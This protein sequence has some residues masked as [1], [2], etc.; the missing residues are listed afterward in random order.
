LGEDHTKYARKILA[1]NGN[2]SS[3]TILFVLKEIMESPIQSGEN[4]F[5]IAFGPGLTMETFL[6]KKK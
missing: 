1:E 5:G 6:C 3:P 2:M 4:I